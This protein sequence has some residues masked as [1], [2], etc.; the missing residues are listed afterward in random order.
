MCY[1]W[2]D[3]AAQQSQTGLIWTLRVQEDLARERCIGS[4]A[5]EPFAADKLLVPVGLLSRPIDLLVL[6]A[7]MVLA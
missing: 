3:A 2:S 5:T 4:E 1:V 6:F 7:V